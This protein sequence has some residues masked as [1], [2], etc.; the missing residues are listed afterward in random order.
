MVVISIYIQAMMVI[1]PRSL[2]IEASRFDLRVHRE[3]TRALADRPLLE[4]S[5]YMLEQNCR[6]RRNEV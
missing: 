1:H 6:F 2:A 3:T 5:E 4:H